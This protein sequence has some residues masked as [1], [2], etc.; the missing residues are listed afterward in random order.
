MPAPAT[1]VFTLATAEAA[2]LKEALAAD[3]WAFSDAP[4]AYL[5]LIHI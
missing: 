3:G 5:S 2:A 4:Y 1:L